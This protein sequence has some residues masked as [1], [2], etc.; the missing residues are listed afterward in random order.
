MA[1]ISTNGTRGEWHGVKQSVSPL[2]LYSGERVRVRGRLSLGF[3][4]LTPTLSPGNTRVE[5]ARSALPRAFRTRGYSYLLQLQT[6]VVCVSLDS[7]E[8]TTQHSV[9]LANYHK[10]NSF[11]ADFIIHPNFPEN[12]CRSEYGGCRTKAVVSRL[13]ECGSWRRLVME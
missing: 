7:V 3:G 10:S 1:D 6:T 9:G 4:P 2:S 5:G 8:R 12:N 11:Y 13:H